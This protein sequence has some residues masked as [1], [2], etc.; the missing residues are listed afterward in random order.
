VIAGSII[1]DARL[2]P[3]WPGAGWL[4]VLA[5]TSQVLGWLLITVS[6]PRLPAALTSL[7][8]CIQPIGSVALA[9]VIFGESPSALQL[10]GVAAVLCAV[11][12]ASLPEQVFRLRTYQ[13][14]RAGTVVGAHVPL[15]SAD[16]HDGL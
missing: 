5:L 8:L 13:R 16:E 9:A 6:L 3:V 2:V 12:V 4:I 7:L 1:G 11:L 15:R 14:R 10:S